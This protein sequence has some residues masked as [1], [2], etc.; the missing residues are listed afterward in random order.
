MFKKVV[1][2]PWELEYSGEEEVN[3][4]PLDGHAPE[5]IVSLFVQASAAAPEQLAP[6]FFSGKVPLHLRPAL[7]AIARVHRKPIKRMH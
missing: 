3:I 4:E 5:E 1:S 7:S 6:G 2:L